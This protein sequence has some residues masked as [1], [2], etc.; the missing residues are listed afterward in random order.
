[1]AREQVATGMAVVA[2]VAVGMHRWNMALAYPR[3]HTMKSHH[4]GMSH[5]S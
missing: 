4:T 1:M 5:T 2:V 3:S